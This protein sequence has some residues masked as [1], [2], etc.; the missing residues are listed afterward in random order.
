MAWASATCSPSRACAPARPFTQGGTPGLH[1]LLPERNP[2]HA[3]RP[4]PGTPRHGHRDHG[5]H[6][7]RTRPR[8][9]DCAC[10]DD[11]DLVAARP[12][13][14][15]CASAAW[16]ARLIATVLPVLRPAVRGHKAVAL[17]GWHHR[18][19]RS[20]RGLP[21]RDLPR[22]YRSDRSG[23]DRSRAGY[24]HVPSPGDAPGHPAAG[25][26]HHHPTHGQYV[27]RPVQRHFVAVDPDDSRVDVRRPVTGRDHVP[28]H[29]HFHRDRLPLPGGLLAKRGHHRSPRATPQGVAARPGRDGHRPT[30]GL[31][32]WAIPRARA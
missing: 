31:L 25:R 21:V 14:D 11:A 10:A 5:G 18:H 16:H 22:W 26:P 29:H 3:A 7:D 23:S 1:G 19:E 20:V 2:G 6:G 9:A 27:H 17:A 12:G 32:R 15:L 24:R 28:P 30:L 13:H 4:S 8:P